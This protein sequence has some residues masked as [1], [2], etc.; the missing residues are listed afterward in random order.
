MYNF[1]LGD[2]RIVIWNQYTIQLDFGQLNII[3]DK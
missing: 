2:K 1:K 3:G